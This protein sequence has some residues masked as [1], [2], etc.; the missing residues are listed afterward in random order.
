MKKTLTFIAIA[1]LFAGCSFFAPHVDQA[2]QLEKQ[3][4]LMQK[5]LDQLTRIANAL[6]TISKK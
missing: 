6:E 4:E 2:Q 5:Q 3:T 1:L